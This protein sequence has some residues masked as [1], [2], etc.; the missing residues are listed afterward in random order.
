MSVMQQDV[1]MKTGRGQKRRAAEEAA[2]SDEQPTPKKQDKDLVLIIAERVN[3]VDCF[4]G[5][6]PLAVIVAQYADPPSAE[7]FKDPNDERIPSLLR[8]TNDVTR[9]EKFTTMVRYEYQFDDIVCRHIASMRN[10]ARQQWP[11]TP[12]SPSWAIQFFPEL[13][14]TCFDYPWPGEESM[15][16]HILD[17]TQLEIIKCVED[18]WSAG[19]RRFLCKRHNPHRKRD[20]SSLEDRK[21]A[22]RGLVLL[23][24][25]R[26][27]A[28]RSLC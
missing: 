13:C 17:F 9:S 1:E 7:M 20:M 24:D 16:E 6:F 18:D 14:D 4:N 25:T 19:L 21:A 12:Q 5:I 26:Q 27:Y 15:V 2:S 11:I 23:K 28:F 22:N 3:A 8:K 10:G